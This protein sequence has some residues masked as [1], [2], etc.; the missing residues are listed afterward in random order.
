MDL[1]VIIVNYNVKYFLEHCLHSVYKSLE[2]LRGEII[3]VDNN[4]VD[5]SCQMVK[6]KFPQVVLIENKENLGFSKANNQGIKISGGKYILI[7]N[8]DTVVQ[9]DTLHKCI[10]FM[11]SHPHAGSLGVKMIDGTGNFLP[12]SKRSLPTPSVSF[13]KIFGLSALFPKSK[14]FGRYHLGFLDKNKIHKVE[15]LS[16]A[17]MFIRKS[18]L[19]KIG[20]FDEAFFMYGEDIDLSYRILL[21][22][23]ENYYFPETTII[24]YKGESTKKGSIN[25]VVIFYKAMIIFA[26][27]HFSPR[28]AWL[29]GLMINMAVYLRASVSIFRRVLLSVLIPLADIGLIFWGFSFIKPIWELHRFGRV[30]YYPNEFLIFVVP[31][32]ILIWLISIYL[33]GGYEKRTKPLDLLRGLSIG[34]IILLLI[35]AL[36]PEHYRYSRALIILGTAWSLIVIFIT[37]LT[38]GSIFKNIQLSIGERRKKIVIAGSPEESRRILSIL[39]HANIQP[40]LAGLVGIEETE[41]SEEYMG[42]LS[43][44]GEIVKINR[45]DEIIFCSRDIPSQQIIQTMLVL[46]DTDVEFKIAPPESLSIIG[47]SSINTA[48]ELYVVHFNSL[49]RNIIRRKKRLFDLSLSILLLLLFPLFILFMKKPMGFLRNI[50]LVIVGLKTWIGFYKTQVSD[51][52]LLPFISDGVITPVSFNEKRLISDEA[53]HRLN[54]L[55]AKDYKILNDLYFVVRDFRFLGN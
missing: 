33:S 30:G 46:G 15:I 2:G 36:L 45:I 41:N 52:G 35:Y 6:E 9:E 54:L 11:G 42:N 27:K 25:Y 53:I 22:G 4:S 38:L 26:R 20:A 40:V 24:H 3:V 10:L 7:L 17:F 43:Q 29:Y 19:D 14:I 44:I 37:R 5:G 50:F 8:P 18:V 55:Y 47:S 49:S 1:S 39:K 16:G 51:S 32:Y 12:E 21:A 34:T 13:Y 48:G 23:Y 31:S 28:Y